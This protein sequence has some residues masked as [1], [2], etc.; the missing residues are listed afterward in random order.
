[1]NREAPN[2]WKSLLGIDVGGTK[3]ATLLVDEHWHIRAQLT[4]PTTLSSPTDTLNGIIEA[5]HATLQRGQITLADLDAIGLGIPG[6]VEPATGVVNLAVN[7]QWDTFPVGPLLRER[8][9]V[10]CF[11]ENDVRAAAWGLY[12]FK[13]HAA[14]SNLAYLSVGTGISAGLILHGQ[15]YRGSHGMAGEI[16]H[17]SLDPTGP[18]CS[19]GGRGCL[20]VLAAGPAIVRMAREAVTAGAVSTLCQLGEPIG[21]SDVYRAAAAGDAVACAITTRVGEALGRAIYNLVLNYDVEHIV[22][23][24][25]VAQAGEVFF[26]PIAAELARL[27]AESHLARVLLPPQLVQL[28]APNDNTGGWGAVAIAEQGLHQLLSLPADAQ[29]RIVHLSTNQ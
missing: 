14:S 24:G 7:L 23:G 18:R 11:L 8:L 15:L 28:V 19:C 22:L 26:R 2:L 10:P 17:S 16:G 6:Q 21:A 13:P 27:S 20:E 4:V 25:G 29:Q 1:M 3:I 9:A 5:I 12:R